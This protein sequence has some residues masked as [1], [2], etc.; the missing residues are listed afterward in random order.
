V[1]AEASPKKINAQQQA[2]RKA[3]EGLLKEILLT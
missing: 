1:T 2:A 3:L